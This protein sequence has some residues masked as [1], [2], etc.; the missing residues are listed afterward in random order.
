MHGLS[1]AL[2]AFLFGLLISVVVNLV[3]A[4]T[5]FM[6][7][8]KSLNDVEFVGFS[9]ARL[10]GSTFVLAILISLMGLVA[11]ALHKWTFFE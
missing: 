9:I 5:R 7:L 11:R 3:M 8:H 2:K 4:G 6:G 10:L 1:F